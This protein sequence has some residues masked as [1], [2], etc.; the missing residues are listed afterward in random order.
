MSGVFRE[1]FVAL[2]DSAYQIAKGLGEAAVVQAQQRASIAY[3]ARP[4]HAARLRDFIDGGHVGHWLC[5]RHGWK[6][7]RAWRNE[8]TGRLSIAAALPCGHKHHF[9]LDELTIERST[10]EAVIDLIDEK[11]DKSRERYQCYCVPRK[12]TVQT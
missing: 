4:S 3:I 2:T 6:S 12:G 7:V 10:P 8:V 9:S 11:W 5:A 1:L